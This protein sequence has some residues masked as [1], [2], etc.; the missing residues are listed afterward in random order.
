MVFMLKSALIP[1][2]APYKPGAMPDGQI[3]EKA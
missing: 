2:R 3:A 1:C